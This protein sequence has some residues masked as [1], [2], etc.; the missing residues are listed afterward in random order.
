MIN[1]FYT[2][3][4]CL[5]AA[6]KNKKSEEVAESPSESVDLSQVCTG[7]NYYTHGEDP[8]LKEDSE[9]PDWLWEIAEPVKSHKELPEDSEKYWRRLNKFNARNNNLIRKQSGL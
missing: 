2:K 9:Y 6:S 1:I 5:G 8:L 4:L 3:T 7:L